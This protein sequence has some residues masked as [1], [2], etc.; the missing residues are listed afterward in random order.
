M[1]VA[2]AL[3]HT[4]TR[5]DGSTLEVRLAL[6][7]RPFADDVVGGRRRFAGRFFH[8]FDRGAVRIDGVSSLDALP[9]SDF[10]LVRDLA[11]RCGVLARERPAPHRCRNCGK[12][13]PRPA[14]DALLEPL[15]TPAH[16]DE[17]ETAPLLLSLDTPIDGVLEVECRA[18]DV[19]DAIALF[20]F[21]EADPPAAIT[22]AIVCGLG[23]VSMH[24]TR[25]RL[26]DPAELARLL[27]DASDDL[28]DVLSA[29]YE[30]RTYPLRCSVPVRCR[31]CE[32]IHDLPTPSL[33]ELEGSWAPLAD[34]DRDSAT[35]PSFDAFSQRSV[36]IADQVYRARDVGGL[37]LVVEDGVPAVDDGGEPLLGSYQPI[38]DNDGPTFTSVRFEITLYYR[39]F[40]SMFE[41]A[42]YDVD[43][44]IEETI[45]HE[46]QHHLYHLAGSDPMDAEERREARAELERTFGKETVRRAEQDALRT[47]L[48]TMMRFFFWGLLACGALLAAAVALGIV[49]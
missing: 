48:G 36:A 29:H 19:V 20:E 49:G 5:V 12:R 42:P 38:Y 10:H 44:E 7:E 28:I 43:A 47:E 24:T 21:V 45:D 35:F 22:P 32:A 31:H 13:L 18:V 16:P 34:A 6:P 41:E 17:E 46:V 15:L 11:E 30:D 1:T 4:L 25:G 26:R 3:T 33:R 40:R 14:A 8:A 27:S 39:T 9:V 23:I 2:P 37:V